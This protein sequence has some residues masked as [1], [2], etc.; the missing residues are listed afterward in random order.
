VLGV[1]PTREL[2]A[3]QTSLDAP[4]SFL[5]ALGFDN[6]PVEALKKHKNFDHFMISFIGIMTTEQIVDIL[7]IV[8]LKISTAD[9]VGKYRHQKLVVFSGTMDMWLYACKTFCT[10]EVEYDYRECFNEMYI[11]FRKHG[12]KCAFE[13]F[14][15][16]T[17]HDGTFILEEKG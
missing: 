13:S 6:K 7:D 17:I 11:R 8:D 10:R 16:K 15:K 14:T 3:H 9:G 2:D 12:F 1:S 5:A 4:A